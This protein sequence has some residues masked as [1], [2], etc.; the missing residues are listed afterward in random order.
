MLGLTW[1]NIRAK[2]VK[3]IGETA[4]KALE[5]GFDIVVT[6]VTEGPGGRLGEDQGAALQPQGHG[7][8]RDHELRARDHRQEGRDHQARQP[9]EPGGAF[10]QA[11]IAI[12][13]TIMLFIEKLTQ[14]AQVVAAFIDSIVAIASGAIGAAAN[15]VER[16]WP[17]CSRW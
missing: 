16:P 17:A 14:I 2:L 4:V 3:A 8:R 13:D 10:I 5:T 6:L 15:K 1:Q 12:Y 9:A 7:D 11:I